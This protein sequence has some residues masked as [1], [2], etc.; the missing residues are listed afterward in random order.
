VAEAVP[1]GPDGP[2]DMPARGWWRALKRATL[3]FKDENGADRAAGLTYYGLLSI[4]PAFIAVVALVGV[5]GQQSTVDEV[6]DGVASVGSE[7]A[8]EAFRGPAERVVEQ[9]SAAGTLLGL[10]L[11]GAVWAASG[12]VGAFGRAMNAAWQV[13]EGRPFWKLRPYMLILTLGILIGSAIVLAGAAISGGVARRA[14]EWVGAGDGAVTAWDIA[15][16]P[17][18]LAVVVLMVALLYWA[19]PN[20]RQPRFRWISP[21]AG[22][23]I[24]TW[25][26]ASALFGL[27]VANLG[28][29]DATYGALG[30]I[31]I[32]LVWLWITNVALLIGAHVDVELER[33]RELRA[34]RKNARR[35]IQL[36]ER[37]PAAG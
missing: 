23:A 33:E 28:S 8:A 17:V 4:F 21:G 32:L 26:V 19:T 6:L 36:P 11:L 18:L 35:R 24:V 22:L 13:E 10:G 31:V 7:Q 34:G 5:L 20:I 37:E 25:L 1:G 9:K 27:Y 30:G 16:W 3:R 29:Y 2:T 12:Y 14:G 15:K